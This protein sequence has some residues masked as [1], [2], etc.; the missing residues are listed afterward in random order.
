MNYVKA[1]SIFST[2]NYLFAKHCEVNF[3][4]QKI[5][6]LVPM[7]GYKIY[8]YMG[9]PASKVEAIRK[10]ERLLFFSH[11]LEVP[12]RFALSR[13]S[14]WSRFVRG[15]SPVVLQIEIREDA[16]IRNEDLWRDSLLS[17]SHISPVQQYIHFSPAIEPVVQ[18]RCD[19]Q[20][21]VHHVVTCALQK[22]GGSIC[23]AVQKGLTYSSR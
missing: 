13:T 19:L 10:R 3:L 18:N 16:E 5:P 7:P 1:L 6:E 14:W 15:D 20:V 12:Q 11:T 4:P 2:A 23:R 8:G 9:C 22:E 21:R 17:R